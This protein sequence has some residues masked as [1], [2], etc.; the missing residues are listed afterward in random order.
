M[1]W[2]SA[3]EFGYRMARGECEYGSIDRAEDTKAFLAASGLVYYP[4]SVLILTRADNACV[5]KDER[6]ITRIIQ[7]ADMSFA[8]ETI[9]RQCDGVVELKVRKWA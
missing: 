4:V 9:A 5:A 6:G 2:I 7:W 8:S 1:T 3:G